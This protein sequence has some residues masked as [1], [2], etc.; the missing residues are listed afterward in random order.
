MLS[1]SLGYRP[2][3]GI[4]ISGIWLTS[5]TYIRM[6]SSENDWQLVLAV[7]SHHFLAR[8][9]GRIIQQQYCV[10]FPVAVLTIQ[11]PD[12]VGE[13]EFHHF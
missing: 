8:V 13:E 11:E 9:I 7:K 10:I 12:E 2:A 4:G 3:A 6:R 5:V 1:K